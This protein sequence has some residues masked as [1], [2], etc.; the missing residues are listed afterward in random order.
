MPEPGERAAAAAATAARLA[1]L[2]LALASPYAAPL[3][4]N[5][6]QD[7]QWIDTPVVALSLLPAGGEA[8]PLNRPNGIDGIGGTGRGKDEDGIGG[9]G[10]GGDSDGVGGTGRRLPEAGSELGFVGVIAGFASICV[11]GQEIHYGPETAITIDG[12]AGKA[13]QLDL[14]QMVSV[15]A[16]TRQGEHHASRIDVYNTLSGP[17][18]AIGPGGELRIL[19]QT[20]YAAGNTVDLAGLAVGDHLTANGSRQPGGDIMLTRL[21]PAPGRDEVS[22]AGPVT[23]V[24]GATFKIFD[25]TIRAGAVSAPTP[26]LGQE[27]FVRGKL[28]AGTLEADTVTIDP[29]LN[30]GNAVRRL[31]LQ[32]HIRHIRSTGGAGRLNVGG[33]DIRLD[34][35]TTVDG[36]ELKTLGEG[37]R[38][39][40]SATIEAG[41]AIVADRIRI[42]RPAGRADR[43]PPPD[44]AERNAP[45]RGND[46]DAPEPGAVP[47]RP[48][49]PLRP[50]RAARG[51]ETDR[52]RP[53]MLR[54]GMLRPETM[55]PIRAERP[56]PRSP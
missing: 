16:G 54:P 44:G 38:I 50:D 20:L 21:E 37:S 42:E 7:K 11:N 19:G 18:Q 24:D 6:C 1:P 17:L 52:P 9:T 49:P 47:L 32:G 48:E 40:V 13:A 5:P 29:Q 45:R 10:R 56:N 22:L 43:P 33:A 53:E 30:F 35:A 41:G 8:N 27:V 34:A 55:R 2:L 3:A 28:V 15:A 39:K 36:A 14:G 23:Q 51:A 26:R 12:R 25:L 31:E 4:A 46:R